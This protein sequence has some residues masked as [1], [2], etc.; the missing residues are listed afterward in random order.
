MTDLSKFL[1]VLNPNP[2]EEYP[3]DLETFVTGE[4]YL[5]H[6]PLSPIQATAVE[7]MSQIY[8]V[9]DLKRFMEP[10]KAEEFYKKYTKREVILQLGKGC[11]DP[12]TPVYNPDTGAWQPL[13]FQNGNVQTTQ[14]VAYATEAFEEGYGEM[15]N[16]TFS[17]FMEE[18]VH[19]GHKYLVARKPYRESDFKYVE[20]KDLKP[21]DRVVWNRHYT[22]NDPV[23]LPEKH[24]EVLACM[25]N[26]HYVVDDHVLFRVHYSKPALRKLLVEKYGGY[27]YKDTPTIVHIE[28]RD[29]EFLEIVKLYNPDPAVYYQLPKELFKCDNETL[30]RWVGMAFNLAGGVGVRSNSRHGF[31]LTNISPYLALDFAHVLMRIGILPSVKY[32]EEIFMFGPD[33]TRGSVYVDSYPHN[34]ILAKL[35]GRGG[36]Y[37]WRNE[38]D[39]TGTKAATILDDYYLVPIKSIESVG[40]GPF[41]TKTVPEHG[42]YVGNGPISANSGKDLLSTIAVAYVVYKLLC[43]KDPAE[44]YGQQSGN[45]IDIINIAINA[46]QAKTVFF[47][48]FKNIIAKSPWFVGKY[49]DT[50]DSISFIKSVTAYSGHSERESHEGLNLIMAVLDEISGFGEGNPLNDSTKSSDNIYLAFS[51]AVAS[52]YPDFG[53]VALLSFPRSKNDFITRHYNEE[54][55]EKEVVQKSHTWIINPELPETEDNKLTINWEEDHITAYKNEK[56][57][58]IRRPSW[59]VNPLRKIEEYKSAF[60][61]NY[62]DSLQRFACMPTDISSDTFFRNVA[63]IDHAMVVRNPVSPNR[64]IDPAWRPDPNITYYVHADLAQQQDK[65]AVAVAHVDH[66]TKIEIGHGMTETVPYVV[67]DMLAWWEPRVEGP[68]DLSE[69][70]RWIMALRKKGLNLGLVTFDRWGSFDLIR[71]LNDRGY[72]AETLSVAKKHYEDFAMLLYE[73]RVSLPLSSELKEEMLALKVVK[74]K[75]DH[76]AKASKDLTDAVT[77]AIF[78]A[79]SR[80]PRNIDQTISVHTWAPDKTDKDLAD[81]VIR[82]T[83][84][85]KQEAKDWL[86]GMGMI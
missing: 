79:I 5:H 51:Q 59:D 75:V 13:M 23:N 55:K 83:P 78:N 19:T 30:V 53:K 12:Y 85:Q 81:D 8:R 25:M 64:I 73:E 47:K 44:Y 27:R 61:A 65:C 54:V 37:R 39:R 57:W 35:L 11:H 40:G 52:R 46:Q 34:E 82:Y 22:V 43:L 7:C 36:K 26:P 86:K 76:P 9:E 4:D 20:A 49:S 77:G 45:A 38:H 3:V 74:N 58:A 15:L 60:V 29:P 70:K 84:E 66:W 50:Q 67:V 28:V 2:F 63:K 56:V 80:T 31:K 32:V 24:L 21:G 41:W 6:K 18:K 68:V 62:Y 48:N 71:E 1:D 72:K 10:Q 33:R 42:H 14:G 16:I 17:N 69:V